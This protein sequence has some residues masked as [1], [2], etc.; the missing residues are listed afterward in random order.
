M[1][2]EHARIRIEDGEEIEVLFNPTTY[3][4]EQSNQLA[5]IAIPGLSAPIVQYV[6]GAGRTLS[7]EL[8]FDTYEQETDVRDHTGKIYGLLGIEA[9]THVPPI[10]TFTWG[11]FNFRSVLQRVSGRFTLFHPDGRPA[12]ATLST[13]WKE[14]LDV[15]VLVRQ[16]PTESADVSKTHKVRRGDTLSGIAAREYGDPAR[17]RAIAEANGI[18]N[19]RRLVPGR[20]LVLPPLS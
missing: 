14:V 12:R 8:F 9:T 13:T 6:R 5:E 19:P 15:D 1:A 4:L 7:M 2:L 16:P 10:C 17:W 3:S 11:H 20:T 18:D